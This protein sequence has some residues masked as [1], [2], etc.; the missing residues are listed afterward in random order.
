M[1]IDQAG[2]HK[3]L[4]EEQKKKATNLQL[5]AWVIESHLWDK[6]N[7]TPEESRETKCHWCGKRFPTEN[8]ELISIGPGDICPKNP[9]MEGLSQE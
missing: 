6:F 8:E 5:R 3:D 2:I 7:T 1:V 9:M 4:T